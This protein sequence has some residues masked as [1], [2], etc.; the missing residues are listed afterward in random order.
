MVE[1]T[2]LWPV[3]PLRRLIFLLSIALAA[4]A[5]LLAQTQVPQRQDERDVRARELFGI[6][7]YAEALVLFGKLYADTTHPTYLRNIG[8][9]YQ[10]LGQADEAI[11]SF[12][13]YLRQ[14][15]NLAPDQRAVV[16]GYIHEMEDLKKRQTESAAAKAAPA[17]APAPA[18]HVASARTPDSS[19]EA[20]AP[21]SGPEKAP[22]DAGQPGAHRT[23]AY[24]V[25]GAGLLALGVGGVFGIEAISNKDSGN[26]EC[27]MDPCSSTALA[28]YNSAKTDARL[29]DIFIGAGLVGAGVAAYLLFTSG[30]PEREGA[31]ST[32]AAGRGVA[33]RLRLLPDLGPGHAGLMAGSSW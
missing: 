14:V 4:P 24:I 23:V 2:R 5:P 33:G 31:R 20:A 16:E 1:E 17:R 12:R 11:G 7:K 22:A 27:A 9:C 21:R 19:A 13:E 8:R 32:A 15:K 30:A 18:S 3:R 26:R 10:N 6:G 29:A 25:A 28:A